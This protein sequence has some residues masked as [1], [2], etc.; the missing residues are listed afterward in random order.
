MHDVRFRPVT[1]GFERLHLARS[2]FE[3]LG[4]ERSEAFLDYL[5]LDR[6]HGAAL[7]LAARDG[8]RAF[9]GWEIHDLEHARRTVSEAFQRFAREASQRAA[10]SVR[11]LIYRRQPT[12]TSYDRLVS[13]WHDILYAL[14]YG[15]RARP[16]TFRT[17]AWGLRAR[18][19]GQL[20][21]RD[22]WFDAIGDAERLPGDAWDDALYERYEREI[23]SGSSPLDGLRPVLRYHETHH[24]WRH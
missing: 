1:D 13:E 20:I 11:G 9:D 22:E 12:S 17:N 7:R 10:R 23:G 5:G 18:E 21:R 8:L 6:R 24:A 4:M 14:A 16:A 3:W 19:L 15:G 2:A